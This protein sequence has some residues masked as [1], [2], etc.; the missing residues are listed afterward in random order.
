MNKCP[1]CET[2]VSEES[3]EYCLNCA[4]EFEYFFDELSLKSKEEY[5]SRLNIQKKL[6]SEKKSTDDKIIK[7]EFESLEIKKLNKKL[8]EENRFLKKEL[9][10]KQTQ[11]HIIKEN[12]FKKN[13]Q[14]KKQGIFSRWLTNSKNIADNIIL[15]DSLMYQ[16]EPF[17][18]LYTW[19]EAKVYAKKLRLGGF[20]DWRVPTKKELMKLKSKDFYLGKNGKYFIQEEFIEN[21]YGFAYFWSSA[22]LQTSGNWGVRFECKCNKNYESNKRYLLCVRDK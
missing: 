18:I 3:Q 22:G 12:D 10:K 17:N 20:D 19:E 2:I 5:D 14:D 15:I 1:I 16:N 8:F 13:K 4:W 21:I 11:S 6:Y 9:I 7:L